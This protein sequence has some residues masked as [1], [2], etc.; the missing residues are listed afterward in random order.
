MTATSPRSY[1]WLQ[2]RGEQD[3]AAL[4]VEREFEP[5]PIAGLNEDLF[6]RVEDL[7]AVVL[8]VVLPAAFRPEFTEFTFLTDISLDLT[9]KIRGRAAL[10][11]KMASRCSSFVVRANE[12]N[13]Q[14]KAIADEVEKSGVAEA[15]QGGSGVAFH[16]DRG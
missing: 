10:R 13:Q 5:R 11:K 16:A 8:S 9:K 3:G 15:S 1:G 12:T 6:R 2:L 7:S 4:L 14:R